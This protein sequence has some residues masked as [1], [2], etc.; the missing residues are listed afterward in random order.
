MEY[1]AKIVLKQ[2]FQQSQSI[3]VTF[4]DKH[5]VTKLIA[6]VIDFHKNRTPY[7]Y[8]SKFSSCMHKFKEGEK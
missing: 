2:N 6:L 3:K 8:L 1:R 4:G 7:T 5:H